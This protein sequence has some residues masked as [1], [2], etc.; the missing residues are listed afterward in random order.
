MLCGHSKLSQLVIY[1]KW[2]PFSR[3]YGVILPSSL[4]RVLPRALEFSSHLPVSVYGTGAFT[5]LEAFLGSLSPT[6][7]YYMFP[8][9]SQLS[10]AMCGFSYTSASLLGQ[11]LPSVCGLSLLRHPVAHAGCR[12]YRNLSP[13]VLR[14]RRSAAP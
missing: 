9:P 1:F 7:R 5:W 6:L 14:L 3:S 12:R 2:H 8:S 11:T 13:V 10:L 4:T